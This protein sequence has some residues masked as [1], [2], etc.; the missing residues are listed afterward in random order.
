M[1][2]IAHQREQEQVAA[3]CAYAIKA[4]R[5]VAERIGRALNLHATSRGPKVWD[6]TGGREP[7]VVNLT[8]TPGAPLCD[9]EHHNK[10]RVLCKH[11]LHCLWIS[12]TTLAELFVKA[13]EVEMQRLAGEVGR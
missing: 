6:V 7:H 12:R 10:R 1:N 2:A 3:A 5:A 4:S 13:L 9:C 8:G 11:I